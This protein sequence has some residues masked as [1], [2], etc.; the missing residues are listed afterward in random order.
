MKRTHKCLPPLIKVEK[1]ILWDRD[2]DGKY[3]EVGI[4]RDIKILGILVFRKC[5]T[6]YTHQMEKWG[7]L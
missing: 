2:N 1:H 5:L 3:Y 4:A 7:T 6:D